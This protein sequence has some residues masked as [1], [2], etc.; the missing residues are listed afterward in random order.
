MERESLGDATQ[1]GLN[2]PEFMS[3]STDTASLILISVPL[4]YETIWSLSDIKI[5]KI[6]IMPKIIEI[7]P[8]GL[9][10]ILFLKIF[11]K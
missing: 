10:N 2:R 11:F 4:I 5:Y 1:S 3:E 8:R 9:A 7:A 6:N